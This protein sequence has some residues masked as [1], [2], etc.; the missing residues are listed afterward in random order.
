MIWD[1]NL[2]IVRKKTDFFDANAT[3]KIKIQ[4]Q[5]KKGKQEVSTAHFWHESPSKETATRIVTEPDNH[6]G[7]YRMER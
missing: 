2:R 1:K 6:Q 7:S 4:T 3:E 5:K